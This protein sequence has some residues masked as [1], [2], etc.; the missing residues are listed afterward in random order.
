MS[1]L[2][3][4][5]KEAQELCETHPLSFELA[6]IGKRGW[7]AVFFEL[8]VPDVNHHDHDHVPYSAEHQD[9]TTAIER[10]IEK[11]EGKR[12]D[13][14]ARLGNYAKD[15]TLTA[16]QL[17]FMLNHHNDIE[18][19]TA[20]LEELRTS[21]E[22]KARFAGMPWDEAYDRYETMLEDEEQP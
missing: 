9:A 6:W 4:A 21:E 22:Y 15:W 8:V 3:D 11:Y 14:P 19:A 13:R 1:H 20:K 16:S 7:R 2:D 10:A 18:G 5:M 12:P 17:E